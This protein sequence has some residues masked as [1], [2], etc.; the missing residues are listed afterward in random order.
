[1][2]L[3]LLWCL[4]TFLLLFFYQWALAVSCIAL[5]G[6]IKVTWLD[7]TWLDP[8]LGITPWG[9]T[10]QLSWK[11]RIK[12]SCFRQF[13]TMNGGMKVSVVLCS[14][15]LI[16]EKFKG[17]LTVKKF[18]GTLTVKDLKGT[19]IIVIPVHIKTWSLLS[20]LESEQ[21]R[22]IRFRRLFLQL[23]AEERLKLCV[24]TVISPVF[25]IPHATAHSFGSNGTANTQGK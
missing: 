24:W 22:R 23:R 25:S 11:W 5:W 7:L 4:F 1:M 3:M 10:E 15:P 21:S 13:L 9:L 18:K 16:V 2:L 12:H 8:M 6:M 20:A 17:T 14:A 19:C